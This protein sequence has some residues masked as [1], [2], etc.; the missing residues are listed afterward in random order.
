MKVNLHKGC[1][2]WTE[3]GLCTQESCAVKQAQWVIGALS[4]RLG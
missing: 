3:D 2:F 1:P 4:D